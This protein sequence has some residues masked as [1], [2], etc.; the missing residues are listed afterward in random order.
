MEISISNAMVR[1]SYIRWDRGRKSNA[2]SREKVTHRNRY[3]RWNSSL[4][5]ISSSI[6]NSRRLNMLCSIS[7]IVANK[8]RRISQEVSHFNNPI[9]FVRRQAVQGRVTRCVSPGGKVIMRICYTT[10]DGD[11]VGCETRASNFIV[12]TKFWMY[13]TL[14]V[15]RPLKLHVASEY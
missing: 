10:D 8:Q 7:S 6:I 12:G 5:I 13:C 9:T 14:F 15:L 2:I 4:S 11:K 1:S 3:V